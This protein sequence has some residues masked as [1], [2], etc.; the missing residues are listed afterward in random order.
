[1]PPK[2]AAAKWDS[3]AAMLSAFMEMMRGHG[4]R[5]LPESCGHDL[6]LV[7][8]EGGIKPDR[9]RDQRAWEC[10]LPG[11]VIAVEG[12]LQATP[13][14][15]RQ[16]T[17]PYRHSREDNP[18]TADF[19]VALVPSY[20][21]DFRDVARALGAQMWVLEPPMEDGRWRKIEDG[22]NLREYSLEDERRCYGRRLDL[23]E[24]D[25]AVTPGLPSPRM[26]THW[27]INAVRFCLQFRDKPAM[28]QDFA[29]YNLRASLFLDNRWA[30]RAGKVGSQWLYTLLPKPTRPDLRYPEV[31]KAVLEQAHKLTK[32]PQAVTIEQV[33]VETPGI[34]ALFERNG[35][36]KGS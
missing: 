20:N 26:V 9:D 4:F 8:P 34:G 6:L 30:E 12:K 11:D 2:K 15:L 27:K 17:P 23:P 31:A 29:R 24:I 36:D 7:V 3:E 35:A 1:M 18:I 19:Y 25:I 33:E 22:P 5:C 16:I 14:L 21:G 10:L 13:T 32:R 28:S